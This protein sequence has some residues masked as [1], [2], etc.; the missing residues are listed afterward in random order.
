M[1]SLPFRGILASSWNS[2]EAVAAVSSAV[3]VLLGFFAS[4]GPSLV[5]N[6]GF[7]RLPAGINT[8]LISLGPIFTAIVAHFV[9][10]MNGSIY[11]KP[12]DS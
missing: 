12:L 6:I 3:G 4:L 5:F 9:L 10:P 7:D 8:L 2:Y 1:G 11:L